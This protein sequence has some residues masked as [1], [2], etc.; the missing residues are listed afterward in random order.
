MLN[1]IFIF[2]ESDLVFL[3]VCATLVAPTAPPQRFKLFLITD[4]FHYSVTVGKASFSAE[5]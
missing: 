2:Q 1:V 4:S 3:L 5:A